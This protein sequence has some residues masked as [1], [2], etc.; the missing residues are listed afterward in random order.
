MQP[1]NVRNPRDL[2]H[3]RK[4]RGRADAAAL[5]ELHVDA[6]D[7]AL[8]GV[9]VLDGHRAL[10]RDDGQRRAR[11]EVAQ[12][13]IAASGE[14]LL[15]ELDAEVH[16]D[17]Q[18]APGDVRGPAGVGVDADR[19]VEDSAHRLERRDVGRAADLDLQR[20][21]VAGPGR[22]LRDDVGGIDAQREVG[23]RDVGRQVEQLVEREARGACRPGRGA[24]CRARTSR[25]PCPRIAT[26]SARR[27]RAPRGRS[28]RRGSARALDG[29]EQPSAGRRTSSP[30]SRRRTDPGSPRQGRRGPGAGVAELDDDRGDPGPA[31]WSEAGDAEERVARARASRTAPAAERSRPGPRA[32]R[33]R[34]ARWPPTAPSARTA[35]DHPPAGPSRPRWLRSS[36]GPRRR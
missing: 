23:R 11:L 22:P 14:R 7:H 36:G 16:Q 2:A 20:R 30:A 29:G 5:R 10:V 31:P 9:E 4:R 13:A 32:A 33:R 24:R 1:R 8:E 34:P 28:G 26:S 6:A 21:E 17:G 18:R 3:S 19:A 35:P 27:P 15:D 25:A 12:P